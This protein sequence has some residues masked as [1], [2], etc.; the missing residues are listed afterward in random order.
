MH[1]ITNPLTN[2]FLF[3]ASFRC[4]AWVNCW[5]REE[6]NNLSAS[7][8]VCRGSWNFSSEIILESKW[9]SIKILRIKLLST[10]SR[11]SLIKTCHRDRPTKRIF[12]Y[13]DYRHIIR[14]LKLFWFNWDF[15]ILLE[16]RRICWL[17]AMNLWVVEWKNEKPEVCFDWRFYPEKLYGDQFLTLFTRVI[18]IRLFPK[19]FIYPIDNHFFKQ[20]SHDSSLQSSFAWKNCLHNSNF[21]CFAF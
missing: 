14:K 1:R 5:L 11:M 4:P 15:P 9:L 8:W 10:L 16:K 20:F 6:G 2:D 18:F 13:N 21:P 3:W 7:S 12:S 19:N 17:Q